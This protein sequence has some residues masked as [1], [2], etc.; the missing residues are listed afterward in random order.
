M[1]PTPIEIKLAARAAVGKA[2]AKRQ[3]VRPKECQG[4]GR[5]NTAIHGHHPDYSK[6][7]E[8]E[9]LC[10]SCHKFAHVELGDIIHWRTGQPVQSKT[11]AERERELTERWAKTRTIVVYQYLAS[12][13][14]VR[15]RAGGFLSKVKAIAEARRLAFKYGISKIKVR[16]ENG[17]LLRE[18]SPRKTKRQRQRKV[19]Q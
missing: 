13:W 8:V 14:R 10:G 6:P 1:N 12:I 4:C 16:D 9:W 19:S 2:I 11:K 3:M 5:T 15:P 17:V 7:L 18:F